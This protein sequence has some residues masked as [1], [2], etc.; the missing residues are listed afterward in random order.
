MRASS[1]SGTAGRAGGSSSTARRAGQMAP[2]EK[3][4]EQLVEAANKEGKLALVTTIG[5]TFRKAVAGF[6]EAFPKITVEHTSLNASAF[7]PRV[8]QERDG[9]IY[10]YD[11]ITSTYGTV[12]LVL[13][14]AGVMD[15]IR[16]ILFRGDIL[17]DNIWQ[18]GFEAGFLDNDK[19]W[20]YAGFSQVHT[21]VSV[22][23][24]LVKEGE[25]KGFD[26][27][28]NPKWKGQIIGGDPR[29]YGGGWWPGTALRLTRGDDACKKL[30][31][32][33]EMT[34]SRGR[35]P[36]DGLSHQG[37]KGH[38]HRRGQRYHLGD[39]P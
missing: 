26:D 1:S 35:A 22:N 14:P 28:L 9:S 3:E 36:N 12:P 27:L 13:I 24:D 4:W 23:T 6:E 18:D 16:P 29:T 2:W 10:N 25:I 8:T 5:D 19:K 32:D 37:T 11:A 21:A 34:F 30:W 7:A 20:S 33:Q 38:R 39:V 31:I 17:D 15:P